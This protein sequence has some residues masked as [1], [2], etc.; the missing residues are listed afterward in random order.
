VSRETELKHQIEEAWATVPYPGDDRI[1][2]DVPCDWEREEMR[3][4][5]VGRHW[6]EVDRETIKFCRDALP[7]LTSEA[8]H[9]YLPTFLIAA[10]DDFWEVDWWLFI[11]LASD[12]FAADVRPLCTPAQIDAL[13]EFLRYY[14]ETRG[15]EVAAEAIAGQ[16]PELAGARLLRVITPEG[17]ANGSCILSAG[18]RRNLRTEAELKRQIEEA[19]GNVN[20]ERWDPDIKWWTLK[21]ETRHLKLPAHM[22]WT[23]EAENVKAAGDVH[24][25]VICITVNLLSVLFRND[26]RLYTPAQIAAIRAYLHYHRDEFDGGDPRLAR[27]IARDWADVWGEPN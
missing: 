20:P 18:L 9:Y 22:L 21:P 26:L 8:C 4:G 14:I 24:E 5:L 3:A 19:W 16:W 13:R 2:P 12:D 6:R 10:V 17:C 27:Q 15:G 25:A 23:L 7:L 11:R 1:V